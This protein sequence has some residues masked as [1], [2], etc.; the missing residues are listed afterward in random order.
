MQY[1]DACECDDVMIMSMSGQ[2]ITESQLIQGC[3]LQIE[4]RAIE[5][6]E[7]RIRD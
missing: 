2:A 1:H 7:F 5:H 4:E 3:A 6:F